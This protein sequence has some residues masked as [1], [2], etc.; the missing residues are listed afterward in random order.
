MSELMTTVSFY[1][2]FPSVFHNPLAL[3]TFRNRLVEVIDQA[4]HF[5]A[6]GPIGAGGS[7]GD[8]A[9]AFR[10]GLDGTERECKLPSYMQMPSSD[11]YGSVRAS[12]GERKED[13]ALV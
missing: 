10:E 7:S 8:T 5:A 11:C 2:P 13:E 12:P 6:L 4:Q 3:Q 1:L 9:Q